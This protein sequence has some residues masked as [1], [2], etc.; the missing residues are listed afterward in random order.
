MRLS[1]RHI[2]G[3]F[4]SFA[5]SGIE[6]PSTGG[7]I[8]VSI[9][10]R[11]YWRKYFESIPKITGRNDE[12]NIY[13]AN[14]YKLAKPIHRFILLSGEPAEIRQSDK[15]FY[16]AA[17]RKNGRH[18]VII[19][20]PS[21]KTALPPKGKRPHTNRFTDEWLKDVFSGKITRKNQNE[22]TAGAGI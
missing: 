6:L 2:E 18:D 16:V 22:F 21:Y 3:S 13:I 10:A 9:K 4:Q 7:N 15:F 19:I 20:Q 1:I 12:V 17:I 8:G 11:K 14:S 5:A